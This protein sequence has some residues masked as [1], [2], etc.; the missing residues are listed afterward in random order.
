[1][2]E[3]HMTKHLKNIL[4]ILAAVLSFST[5]GCTQK[6]KNKAI[7]V[8]VPGICDDSPVYAMLV[9]GVKNAVLEFNKNKNDDVELFVMEAGTNQAEWS[10]KLTALA[11]EQLYDVIISSNPS[12]PD[13]AVPILEQFPNQK[14]ILL[15]A[16]LEGNKNIHTVCYNQYEQS[17]L[18]GYIGS[19]MSKTHK[20]GL[21][22]AQEYPVMNNIIFPFFEKGAKD[23]NSQTSVDFRV[24][25]N[26]Y[27]AT[28]GS[29]IADALCNK[30][31][32]VILPICGGAAQGV[33]KSA[34][35]NGIYIT[36]FD[37][38][39][40]DKAPG[41]IISSTMMEQ[42]QMSQQVTAE[43]LE[44]KTPWGSAEM[45]GIK[46]G[47]ITFVEDD[48]NYIKTVPQEIRNKM[49]NIIEEIKSGTLEIK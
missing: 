12:L 37:N 33:I 40:F 45:V 48:Q 44:G 39:G 20:I 4:L 24:V 35:N 46:E 26:W 5:F 34:V 1:M 10:T 21:I 6:S 13:L 14:F 29:E 49:H 36:W 25:G 3:I 15:D 18:T 16:T 19:L 43:F 9:Q 31:V 42:V 41:T 30:G 2:E 32:D 38:N 27:D 11:A 47:Y 8:F 23:A 7:A 28:K 22:A 17:Y